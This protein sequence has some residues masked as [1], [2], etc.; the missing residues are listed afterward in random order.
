MMIF[1]KINDENENR[2]KTTVTNHCRGTTPLLLVNKDIT[3]KNIVFTTN[4]RYLGKGTYFES[5]SL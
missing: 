1:K 3:I 2:V 5:V 4:I